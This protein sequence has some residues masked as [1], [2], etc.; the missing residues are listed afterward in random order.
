VL[1]SQIGERAEAAILAALVAAGKD[2]LL[3]YGQR[4]YDL[5][6]EQDGQLVKI[7]CKAGLLQNGVLSFRTHSVGR[8][9]LRDYRG[10]VDLFG[11]YCHERGEVYLVPIAD[12]PTS[13]RATLRLSPTL[14]GQSA[15]IRHGAQYLLQNRPDD[16]SKAYD[17]AVQNDT[18]EEWL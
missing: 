14:N 18:E 5:A 7:Q 4:R 10:E 17:R 9:S 3:P 1:P 6:I 8:R 12:V 13:S 11:V 15:R 2:V 16:P